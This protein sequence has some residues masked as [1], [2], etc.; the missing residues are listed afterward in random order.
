MRSIRKCY[1]R[2]GGLETYTVL[3]NVPWHL[4]R[5]IKIMINLTFVIE[6][7]VITVLSGFR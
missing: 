5:C 7:A 3:I 2:G 6:Y 4:S 1:G